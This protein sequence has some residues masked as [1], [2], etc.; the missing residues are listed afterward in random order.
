MTHS[1]VYV[2]QW[3]SQVSSYWYFIPIYPSGRLQFIFSLVSNFFWWNDIF[4]NS[5]ASVYVQT[6]PKCPYMVARQVPAWCLPP[7]YEGAT[8][9]GNHTLGSV[10][11]HH[12]W[13]CTL[14]P[15]WLCTMTPHCFH[16]R[17]YGRKFYNGTKM[18]LH[19]TQSGKV[20]KRG[21]QAPDYW[22]SVAWQ[23]QVRYRLKQC[24][25]SAR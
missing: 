25:L 23:R 12:N 19:M 21:A 15:H 4:A 22:A 9:D 10:R 1:N 3:A 6:Y 14:T 18:V 17:H 2:S 7:R 16:L 13:F 11:R 5:K 8:G 20:P 24:A